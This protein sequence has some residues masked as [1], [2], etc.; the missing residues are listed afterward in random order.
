MNIV[1]A[2]DRYLPELLFRGCMVTVSLPPTVR[3]GQQV[4]LSRI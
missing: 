3:K 2:S 4:F 1:A